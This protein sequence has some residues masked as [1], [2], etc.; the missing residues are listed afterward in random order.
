M[1]TVNKNASGWNGD[2]K[3]PWGGLNNRRQPILK[4]HDGLQKTLIN[5]SRW[6]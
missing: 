5:F 3:D 4:I 2:N 1:V 6:R